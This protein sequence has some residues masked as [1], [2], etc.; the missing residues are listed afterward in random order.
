M[1][2]VYPL[3][4]HSDFPSI[5]RGNLDTVQVNLG[6]KC[7]QSC[8]HCHVNAGPNRKEEMSKLTIRDILKFID[9]FK[10]SNVD[11]T[12]GAPELNMNF[13]FFVRELKN[14]GCHII[15]RCNLTII[16]EKSMSDL[17][18]FFKENEVEIIASLPCYIKKNVDKQ[19]GKDVFDKSIQALKLLN[20]IGYG[21]TPSLRLNLVYNPQGSSLPPNQ[22]KLSI[23]YQRFLYDEFGIQFNKLF[24]IT[25]MPIA[26]FGSTLISKNKFSDYI[27]LLKS[28]FNKKNINHLMCKK[29]ISIDYQ[30]YVY[31]CDF[32]QMLNMNLGSNKN[33]IHIRDLKS[34]LFAKKINT[35][36]HCFGCTAGSGSSCGG[37]LSN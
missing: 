35:A 26:R 36:D 34:S 5:K 37:T 32:N 13:R 19:R 8:V 16:L 27:N 23:D 20:S 12:G 30:G 24:T 4:K 9:K 29:L 18:D 2:D 10:I 21:L 7:N 17:P 31:D 33:K 15:D 14:R 25:N 28:S 3:L 6:Y 22:E 11:L 1:H